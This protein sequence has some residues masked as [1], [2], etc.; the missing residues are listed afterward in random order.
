MITLSMLAG[1]M[2][3]FYAFSQTAPIRLRNPP[4]PRIDAGTRLGA[5]AYQPAAAN[6][7]V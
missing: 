7:S 1:T 4:Q 6:T 2:L 3:P 5:T